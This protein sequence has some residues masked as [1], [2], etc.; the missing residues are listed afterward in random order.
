MRKK[1]KWKYRVNIK[2][3][4]LVL[5]IL[6]VCL[7]VGLGYAI[8]ESS[9]GIGGT[10]N[11]AKY[12]KT[13]YGVFVKNYKENNVIKYTGDHNDAIDTSKSTEDIYYWDVST[14]TL[15]NNALEK[16]N[17]VFAD[18]CWQ[19]YRTTDTGGVKL[20]Y[21]GEADITDNGDGTYSYD[22]TNN[23]DTHSGYS[24]YGRTSLNNLYYYASNYN[25]DK[26]T[27]KYSLDYTNDSTIIHKKW[28]D[29][30]ADN[31][32]G[33][34]TCRS[35][36]QDATCDTLYYVE[37]YYSNT[38]A[39]CMGLNSSS[40]YYQ[41]GTMPYSSKINSPAYAGYM[42]GDVYETKNLEISD[43]VTLKLSDNFSVTNLNIS[44]DYYYSDNILDYGVT[45]PNTY[46][47]DNPIQVTSDMDYTTLVGKYV[48]SNNT[49]GYEVYYVVGV[50]GTKIYY[51]LLQNGNTRHSIT[52]ADDISD[53]QDNTYTLD[54][55]TTREID[56]AT[57][58]TNY[59][60]Y[61]FKY[62]CGDNSL[63]CSDMRYIY[64][65]NNSAYQYMPLSSKIT[66]SKSINGLELV[67]PVTIRADEWYKAYNTTY[68]DYKYTCGNNDIICT[69]QN[70]KYMYK[71]EATQYF[72]NLN[73]YYG[74][75]VIYEN[76]V[77]KLQDIETLDTIDNTT[78]S[79]T[80]HYVC[81]NI[82][83]KECSKVLYI[84]YGTTSTL[85]V[86]ELNDANVTSAQDV[87]DAMLNKNTNDSLFKKAV[88]EWYE[89][90]LL[91]YEDYLDDAIYC[92]DRSYD[93]RS[94]YTF[95]DSGW[96]DNGGLLNKHLYFRN[97]DRD[98]IN[99]LGC[100]REED[101]F[102]YANN[103]AHL[104]HKVGL[105]TFPEMKL[106][107]NSTYRVT[108]SYY[109][110]LSPAYYQF[111]SIGSM[112][113]NSNGGRNYTVISEANGVRPVI[114]LIPKITYKSGSGEKDNPYIV[115][116]E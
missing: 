38:Q 91:G 106:L 73:H 33:Y 18:H 84:Y 67:N 55:S 31:L 114:T 69:E 34:Y 94:G 80:H 22:C 74:K 56:Y 116:V 1:H 48:R 42:Y 54:S 65:V 46:T 99:D 5:V 101:R 102:S 27:K 13:L 26:V 95:N 15:A 93:P 25:Y 45:T 21:N 72:Y 11:V 68:K 81:E 57:W 14:D 115:N 47:L 76:G 77:Y 49:L 35:N 61:K 98:N 59:N 96:N 40:Y 30:E 41:F 64:G 23:R 100:P 6:G 63:T 4:I 10:L 50:S 24:S 53:N 79:S 97:N 51:A 7:F 58:Y 39:N 112:T 66:F 75:S 12:D 78:K 88:D 44:T 104:K 111:N 82:G 17:V 8:L 62:T 109:K 19:M 16:N 90:Y 2:K 92:G 110:L 28:S 36:T 86:V 108:G 107:G 103:K 43:T 89:E 29:S 60:N 9:L 3:K 85:R 32:I 70:L 20:M 87:L 52:I 83:E 105:A 37:S 71:K 113:I